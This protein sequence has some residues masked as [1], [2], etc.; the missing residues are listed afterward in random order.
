MVINKAEWFVLRN[1]LSYGF[2]AYVFVLLNSSTS[3]NVAIPRQNILAH[4]HAAVRADG[5]WLCAA[6]VQHQHQLTL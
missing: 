6:A 5:W 1:H 4:L 3:A 2:T